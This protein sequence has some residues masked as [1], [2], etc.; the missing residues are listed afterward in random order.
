MVGVA[1]W[2][3]FLVWVACMAGG[4]FLVWLSEV[5]GFLGWG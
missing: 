3:G 2:Y 1:S 4:S 5:G